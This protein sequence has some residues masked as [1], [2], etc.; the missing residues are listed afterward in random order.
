MTAKVI[1]LEEILAPAL[2]PEVR[3]ANMMSLNKPVSS[4]VVCLT[5]LGSTRKGKRRCGNRRSLK[6]WMNLLR[7]VT[8]MGPIPHCHGESQHWVRQQ[9]W[10]QIPT[11]PQSSFSDIEWV[12]LSHH[13][14]PHRVVAYPAMNSL[15]EGRDKNVMG[16]TA[17]CK[18]IPLNARFIKQDLKVFGS[19]THYEMQY[20]NFFL[21]AFSF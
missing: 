11:L 16:W 21:F 17:Q 6:A 15:E 10:V 8:E 2:W 5:P 19:V 1:V 9:V 18:K 12:I 4:P 13:S 7:R 14:L 20:R 3:E